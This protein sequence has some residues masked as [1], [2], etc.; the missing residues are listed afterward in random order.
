MTITINRI[1]DKLVP[2]QLKLPN[3]NLEN[4]PWSGLGPVASYQ[5]KLDILSGSPPLRLVLNSTRRTI[6]Y[7]VVH[8]QIHCIQATFIIDTIWALF[9]IYKH[10]TM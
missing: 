2:L 5:Y 7:H 10:H 3:F 1:L 4:C 8:Q 6:T 9:K